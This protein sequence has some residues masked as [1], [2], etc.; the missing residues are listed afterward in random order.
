[1]FENCRNINT[2]SILV[3]TA[4]FYKK[5]SSNIFENIKIIFHIISNDVSIFFPTFWKI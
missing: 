2:L 4:K 1:M 5:Y 3:F